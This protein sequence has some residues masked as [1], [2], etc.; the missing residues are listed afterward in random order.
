[1]R[2]SIIGLLLIGSI[3]TLSLTACGGAHTPAAP[4][5]AATAQT[6]L[7][8]FLAAGLPIADPVTFTPETDPNHLL[9]R[10]HQYAAKLS[11][12]DAR[13]ADSG[14]PGLDT[15]GTLEVFASPADRQTRQQYVE[16]LA[17]ASSLFAEYTF[18]NGRLLLRLSSQLTPAQ[19]EEY[20]AI[21][22]RMAGKGY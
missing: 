4:T 15:G 10:P 18:A 9:G 7:A 19:A 20:E 2:T 5:P 14:E 21:F 11:W 16:A 8:A 12:R 3:L 22:E 13:V 17:Q 1:M 6:V